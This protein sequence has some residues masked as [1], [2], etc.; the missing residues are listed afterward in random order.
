MICL[1]NFSSIGQLSFSS[2]VNSCYQLLTADDR[3]YEK[4]LNEIFIYV[5]KMICVP[6]FRSL[7]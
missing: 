6:N 7:G 2:A 5:L 1:P 4:N 3:C